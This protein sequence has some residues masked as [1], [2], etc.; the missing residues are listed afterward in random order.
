MKTIQ[1]RSRDTQQSRKR[2]TKTCLEPPSSFWKHL[3]YRIRESTKIPLHVVSPTQPANFDQSVKFARILP[4][5]SS[6]DATSERTI[7]S[8]RPNVRSLYF[9]KRAY[10]VVFPASSLFST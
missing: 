3:Y 1:K 10:E 7:I 8:N 9:T 6:W 2:Q 4:S 5:D